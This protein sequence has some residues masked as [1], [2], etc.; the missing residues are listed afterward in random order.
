MQCGMWAFRS[1]QELD[2]PRPLRKGACYVDSPLIERPRSRDWGQRLLGVGP[3]SSI[4]AAT[5]FSFVDLFSSTSTSTC[6]DRCAKLVDAILL[7]A[8]ACL[9]LLRSTWLIEN[10]VNPLTRPLTISRTATSASYSAS[11]LEAAN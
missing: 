6:L 10:V 1:L 3:S 5:S 2:L 8:S 7:R 9:F 4:T 11:L